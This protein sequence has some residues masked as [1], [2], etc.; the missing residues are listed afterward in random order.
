MRFYRKMGNEVIDLIAIAHAD[1]LSAQGPAITK[2]ITDKN[3]SG[4]KELLE[5]YLESKND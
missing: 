1:R 5:Y 3:I 2:E 4:L